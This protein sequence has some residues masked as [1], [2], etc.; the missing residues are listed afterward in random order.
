MNAD[1]NRLKLFG[2][3]L[4]SRCLSWLISGLA[5]FGLVA[6]HWRLQ[7]K[8]G[9]GFAEIAVRKSSGDLVSSS[10]EH[11]RHGDPSSRVNCYQQPYG[12]RVSCLGLPGW[13]ARSQLFFGL[14]CWGWVLGSDDF[15]GWSGS[16]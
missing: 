4:G 3:Y 11:R 15:W 13:G 9:R 6:Q 14:V 16:N 2:N 5:K 1:E 12:S 8:E 10:H 7:R